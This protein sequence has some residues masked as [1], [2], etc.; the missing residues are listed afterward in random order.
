MLRKDNLLKSKRS[1]RA[2]TSHHNTLLKSKRSQITIFIILAIL[3]VVAIFLL[4]SLFQGQI[5]TYITKQS[6]EPNQK[7]EQCVNEIVKDASEKMIENA[8]YIKPQK[9]SKQFGYRIGEADEIPLKNYTY[10]C[11][12]PEFRVRCIAK[13]GITIEH[14]KQE[15]YNYA[16]PKIE[17][18]FTN[19]K[20]ELE[21]SGYSV[22]LGSNMSF[23]VE[24]IPRAIRIEINRDLQFEKSGQSKKFTSYN[25]PT[26]SPLYDMLIVS[27]NIVEE[28]VMY[29]NSDYVSIMN[30][31]KNFE[32]NKFTTS[33]SVRI[34]TLKDLISEE[35]FRFAVRGCVKPTPN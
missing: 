5:K 21:S 32:I 25:V 30:Q 27:Q 3:I 17:N 11:Y 1:T 12:T 20:K 23:S 28:E 14:A 16:K 18:C 6:M 13:E 31:Y 24:L 33:D 29:C 7:I 22:I 9:L 8:G 10:L 26:G 15:I 34:Y 4:F 19:M 35:I 2:L